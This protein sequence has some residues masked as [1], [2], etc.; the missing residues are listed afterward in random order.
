M[1]S[2]SP[3]RSDSPAR[4]W[5][6]GVAGGWR[7]SPSRWLAGGPALHHLAQE[8]SAVAGAFAASY[9]PL[10]ESTKRVFRFFGLYPGKPFQRAGRRRA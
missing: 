3:W 10:A 7:T 4:G 8:E 5:R 6:T 1:R 2:P 9:E